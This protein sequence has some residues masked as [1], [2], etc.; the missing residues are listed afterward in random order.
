[1]I[2]KH[3]HDQ[4]EQGEGVHVVK[5]EPCEDEKHGKG[6]FTE[7]RVYLSRWGKVLY[8]NVSLVDLST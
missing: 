5:N 7:K 1:M 8:G 3:S 6:Q 2:S 4:S